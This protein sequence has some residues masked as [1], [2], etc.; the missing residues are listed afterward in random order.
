MS[1]LVYKYYFLKT[2]KKNYKTHLHKELKSAVILS[3]DL[4]K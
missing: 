2:E 1:L 4:N 3:C